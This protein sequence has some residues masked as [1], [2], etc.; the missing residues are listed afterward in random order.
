MTDTSP[1]RDAAYST[2]R[3][4]RPQDGVAV[5][6]LDR[7]E[8]LN[9]MN[10]AMFAELADAATVLDR[11]RDLRV[12]VITGNGRGFCAGYD[13]DDAG[14]LAGLGALGML[15]LQE[16]AARA[17]TAMRAIRI[18][19]IAAVNGAATGGGLCLAL[20]ADIRVA[21][22]RAKFS[23]AFVR[24]GLSA[25]D[26]GLSWV[27][28]RL[29]GPAVAAEFA[30]TARMMEADEAERTGLVNRVVPEDQL[31]T[32]ALGTAE[33]IAANSPGGV[34]V[35][36]AALRANLEVPSYAAA[37][38][39]ENRGQAMLST[40]ADMSEALAAFRERRPPDFEGR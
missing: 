27:L 9:A 26:L 7:P 13:L 29:I 25:G 19:V 35:T 21:N 23:A 39:L 16:T 38:E 8:H 1:A 6:V 36:K 24:I 22:P 31:M 32:S 20:T 10:P 15:D 37:A 33:Q 40:T 4:E 14:D 28:P 2:L 30:L 11:A 12:V 5:L 17:I 18:P 3:I 34:R